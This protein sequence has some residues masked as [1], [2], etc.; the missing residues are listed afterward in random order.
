MHEKIM[1]FINI[2]PFMK[3]PSIQVFLAFLRI[4]TSIFILPTIVLEW[5]ISIIIFQN[6]FK[7][8]IK[9][10]YLFI[11]TLASNI[12][13]TIIGLIILMNT[14]HVT[15]TTFSH[16]IIYNIFVAFF[17]LILFSVIIE[18]PILYVIIAISY[19]KSKEKDNKTNNVKL[20][21]K[22]IFIATLTA[23]VVQN[24]SSFLII[25][26]LLFSLSRIYEYYFG[27]FCCLILILPFPCLLIILYY[28]YFYNP[29]LNIIENILYR[30]RI[31]ID[32]SKNK[33]YFKK[34]INEYIFTTDNID[35]IFN[36]AT[37]QLTISDKKQKVTFNNVY[38]SIIGYFDKYNIK[39][40][41]KGTIK[42]RHKRIINKW[43]ENNK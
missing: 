26:F 33:L 37:Y 11:A 28:S 3:D 27:K 18:F 25:I 22:K 5:I 36:V 14:D 24:V 31:D 40:T 6:I 17:T 16:P 8:S 39:Y 1:N 32:T 15:N 41:L 21:N 30:Y 10:R 20:R 23:C 2:V 42:N 13:T 9:K 43:I 7:I 4:Q 29:S 35:I 19:K 12:F 38:P 34:F